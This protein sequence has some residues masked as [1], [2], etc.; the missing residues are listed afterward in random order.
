MIKAMLTTVDNPH[1]PFENFK[2]WYIWDV[3]AGYH[4]CGVL[5]KVIST[6][7]ELSE[8]QQNDANTEAIDEIVEHNLTGVYRKLT[9]E[10]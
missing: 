4:C 9:K 5:A 3:A 8:T 2:G 7:Y 6:S 1:D 10:I